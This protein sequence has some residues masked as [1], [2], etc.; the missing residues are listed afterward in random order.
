LGLSVLVSS[1]IWGPSPEFCYCKTVAVLSMWVTLSDK[2]A[3]L[4]F[5]VVIVSSTCHP[6]LHFYVPS[7]Y[8][9]SQL[10]RVGFL[11]DTYCL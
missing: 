10:L 4:S 1:P 11:V 8:V 6:Y 7:F 9:H 3:G 5:T 2:G